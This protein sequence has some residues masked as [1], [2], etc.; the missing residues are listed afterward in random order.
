MSRQPAKSTSDSLPPPRHKHSAVIHD[1]AIWIYGGMTDLQ[2]RS[3]LWKWDIVTGTWVGIKTKVNPG[4]LHS[5]AACRLPS[6]MLVFGG[7]RDGHPTNDLWKFNFSKFNIVIFGICVFV[8]KINKSLGC[9]LENI[10]GNIV[11]QI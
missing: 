10:L 1:D 4:P 3:D 6:C 9:V 8:F 7:E 2:E 11:S 5:H